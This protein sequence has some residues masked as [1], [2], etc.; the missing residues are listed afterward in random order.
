MNLER[1]NAVTFTGRLVDI[2]DTVARVS[3]C[4]KREGKF[5]E[6]YG[7][8]VKKVGYA[9]EE[10]GNYVEENRIKLV[11]RTYYEGLKIALRHLISQFEDV[12]GPGFR[13]GSSVEPLKDL[14]GH[15]PNI[16]AALS[17]GSREWVEFG[18]R[19]GAAGRAIMDSADT[20]DLHEAA[21]KAAE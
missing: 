11:G 4:A 18:R 3:E 12:D 2:T 19:L 5:T 13:F 6:E 8:L 20:A 17:V 9:L 10:A 1:A 15:V 7:R 14:V 21:R 16:I